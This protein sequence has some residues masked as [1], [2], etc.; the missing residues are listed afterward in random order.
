[1]YQYHPELKDANVSSGWKIKSTRELRKLSVESL[2]QTTGIA[3]ERIVN[4]EADQAHLDIEEFQK[5]AIALDSHPSFFAFPYW[6]TEPFKSEPIVVRGSIQ[7][8]AESE[9]RDLR[10]YL[11]REMGIN[12]SLLPRKSLSVY[13]F[14]GAMA[15]LIASK[16]QPEINYRIAGDS[17]GLLNDN[18][19]H[20]ADF[21]CDNRIVTEVDIKINCAAQGIRYSFKGVAADRGGVSSGRPINSPTGDWNFSVSFLVP[22]DLLR[23]FCGLYPE[24]AERLI[25]ELK[26][27][28]D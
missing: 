28:A 26:K 7:V 8:N 4:A 13:T 12:I 3:I 18:Y 23:S 22:I 21:D 6:D 17:L 16:L 20:G 1:M 24:A 14:N 11:N 27:Y 15:T 10:V 19:G 25:F 5:I 2:S 9:I